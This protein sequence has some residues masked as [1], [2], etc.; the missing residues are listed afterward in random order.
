MLGRAGEVTVT[1]AGVRARS[2]HPSP[3][4][5]KSVTALPRLGNE[6]A[7]TSPWLRTAKGQGG[8]SPLG[9]IGQLPAQMPGD[10]G[11]LADGGR[12]DLEPGPKPV[13]YLHVT[14]G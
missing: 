5:I 10:H 2:Y 14:C 4:K 3:G 11:W 6:R 1:G 9:N 8:A 12:E 7:N 13:R